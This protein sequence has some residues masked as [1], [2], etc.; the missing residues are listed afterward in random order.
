MS[1]KGEWVSEVEGGCLN[2]STEGCFCL[3]RPY[4]KRLERCHQ[5]LTPYDHTDSVDDTKLYDCPEG[6]NAFHCKD[7]QQITMEMQR[8][9][10]A[11]QRRGAWYWLSDQMLLFS[12]QYIIIWEVLERLTALVYFASCLNNNGSW[13]PLYL[14]ERRSNH[15]SQHLI[16]VFNGQP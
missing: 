9:N 12:L 15:V 10:W 16:V 11:S 1:P 5:M 4:T 6:P 8:S 3:N 7:K 2:T 14:H 13:V